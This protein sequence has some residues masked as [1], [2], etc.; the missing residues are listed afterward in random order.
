MHIED[1]VKFG[2]VL[3]SLLD[4]NGDCTLGISDLEKFIFIDDKMGM[5]VQAG[6]PIKEGSATQT[7]IR[8]KKPVV[9]TF[10]AD[11]SSY[12]TDY[13]SMSL[14]LFDD[15]GEV[16]GCISWTIPTHRSKLARM[17]QELSALSQE[18]AANS[19]QFARHA[20]GL[21]EA[22]RQIFELSEK[23][24]EQMRTIEKIN[25]MI[26]ELASQTHLLGLNASIEAAHAGDAG[27]GFNVVANAIRSLAN[28]SK[29]SAQD[30]AEAL[31]VTERQVDQIYR[32]SQ[33]VTR[34]GEQQAQGAEQMAAAIRQLS[35]M[36]F[37]LSE[38]AAGHE[39]T[40]A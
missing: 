32:N 17:A 21:S 38:M 18:L 34:I 35:E 26:T 15:R 22:N 19:E 40:P 13:T 6:D 37:G 30:I 23:L 28:E 3:K 16:C 10:D 31:S 5:Q 29:K 11:V 12:A 25:E 7:A 14:P 9:R 33:H 39:D 36:A 1:Y 24:Q 4:L 8:Q 20:E 2:P 27:L